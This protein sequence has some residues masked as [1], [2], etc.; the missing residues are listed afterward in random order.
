MVTASVFSVSS[1]EPVELSNDSSVRVYVPTAAVVVSIVTV[2]EGVPF[3]MTTNG[4]EEALIYL[5]SIYEPHRLLI[6][7]E[8]SSTDSVF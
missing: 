3:A 5:R 1:E 6:A 4:T 8:T 7:E 2:A